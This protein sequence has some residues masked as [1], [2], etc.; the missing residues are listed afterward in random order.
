[1]N[2]LSCKFVAVLCSPQ[3]CAI[4]DEVSQNFPKKIA[5]CS[6]L[7]GLVYGMLYSTYTSK[8]LLWRVHKAT[9]NMCTLNDKQCFRR[10][11]ILPTHCFF[12]Y[13]QHHMQSCSVVNAVLK[14]PWEVGEICPTVPQ[15]IN[16]RRIP[17]ALSNGNTEAAHEGP[18]ERALFRRWTSV[19]TL[20]APATLL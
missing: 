16:S 19:C 17:F 8:Q 10:E 14:L 2:D 1:M 12:F 7:A 15:R 9:C 18:R 5:K 3:H 13:N 20:I 11:S 4:I 6:F